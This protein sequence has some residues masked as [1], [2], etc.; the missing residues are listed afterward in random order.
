MIIHRKEAVNAKKMPRASTLNLIS[1]P[2]KIVNRLNSMVLPSR[3]IGSIDTTMENFRTAAAMVQ[4]SLKFGFLPEIAIRI[5][6]I[7]DTVIA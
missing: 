3:M 2:G 4:N 5:T 7:R 1:R 6:L